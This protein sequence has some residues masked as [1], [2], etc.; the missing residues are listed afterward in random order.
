M[1][2]GYIQWV[3]FI[4]IDDTHEG[5]LRPVEELL[6]HHASLAETLIQ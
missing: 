3:E 5:K 1:V 2:A 4:A 6:D